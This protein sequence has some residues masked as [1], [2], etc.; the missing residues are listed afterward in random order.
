VADHIPVRRPYPGLRPFETHEAEIFFGREAHVDRLLEILQQQR[1]LAVIGPSGC[2]KSSLV[3]AGLLPAVLAGWLGTGSD[4]RIAK[5]RPGDRPLHELGRTLSAREVFDSEEETIEAELARGKRGL[6]DSFEI[7]ARR[8]NDAKR[9]NLLILVDQFEELFTYEQSRDESTE[10]VNLLLAAAK[11]D[12]RIHIVMTMRTDFLGDCVQ[13]LQLPDAINRGMFLTPRLHR[14]EMRTAITAPALL[15]GGKVD[16]QLAGQLVNGVGSESDELPILQH[17]LARMWENAKEQRKSM[18][19]LPDDLNDIGGLEHALSAHA[20]A[21]YTKLSLAQQSLAKRLFQSIT[22]RKS[23]EEGSRDVRQPRPL[24]EIAAAIPNCDWTMLVPIAEA[25]AAD[26]VNFL[27]HGSKL[28][29]KSVIDLSHE[30]LIRKWDR[31]QSWVAEEAERAAGY[32]RWR[33]R[34]ESKMMLPTV[35]LLQAIRWRDGAEGRM[36]PDANWATRYGSV[37]E[38][39]RTVAHIAASRRRRGA[40]WAAVVAVLFAVAYIGLQ[41][42]HLAAQIK[43]RDAQIKVQEA[44]HALETERTKLIADARI[45]EEQ[46]RAESDRLVAV[47]EAELQAQQKAA[48][49]ALAQTTSLEAKSRQLMSESQVNAA[50]DPERAQLLAIKAYRTHPFSESE[51]ML[52]EVRMRYASLQRTLRSSKKATYT[53]VSPDG[54]SVLTVDEDRATHLWDVAAGRQSELPSGVTE[55]AYSTNGARILLLGNGK[56]RVW[57]VAGGRVIDELSGSLGVIS[58]DGRSLATTT[59]GKAAVRQVGST[60]VVTTFGDPNET[61]TAIAFSA[62]GKLIATTSSNTLRLWSAS[63]GKPMLPPLKR[64]PKVEL[65]YE[66]RI[67]FSDDGKHLITFSDKE[68]AQ[69]WDTSTGASVAL[70]AG[71]LNDALFNADGSTVVTA[72]KDGTAASWDAS[73]GTA[74]GKIAEYGRDVAVV[75]IV[76]PRD[77]E[78]VL[79]T[80][81]DGKAQLFELPDGELLATFDA[82]DGPVNSAAFSTDGHTLVTAHDHGVRVWN[83][84]I[85]RPRRSFSGQRSKDH[86]DLPTIAAFTPDGKS[87]VAVGEETQV[88][89]LAT[90]KARPSRKNESLPVLS[91]DASTILMAGADEKTLDVLD[92]VSGRRRCVLN[93]PAVRGRGAEELDLKE[94]LAGAMIIGFLRVPALRLMLA[95]G[96]ELALSD[97]GRRVMLSDGA[98]TYVWE[99]THGKLIAKFEAKFLAP[100]FSP[101]GRLI[102]AFSEDGQISLWSVDSQRKVRSHYGEKESMASVF[103][104]DAQLFATS[105]EDAVQLWDLRND[106]LIRT[107]PHEGVMQIVFSPKGESVV[108]MDGE[109]RTL[110]WNVHTGP[111][112]TLTAPA[113]GRRATKRDEKDKTTLFAAFN[114]S[115][116][117][118]AASSEDGTIRLWDTRTGRQLAVLEGNSGSGVI[119]FDPHDKLILSTAIEDG[120]TRIWDI[121]GVTDSVDQ[122]IAAIEHRIGLKADQLAP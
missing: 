105:D 43:L 23:K 50:D 55:A 39:E 96:N 8:A 52:R 113:R 82:N 62:D 68:H 18:T 78:T 40:F 21:V 27:T 114:H 116:T 54:N 107:L 111:S 63:D 4:W 86:E 9:L 35:E 79:I 98:D 106:R 49:I 11:E 119:S 77:H 87:I 25:F 95:V 15:F 37:K 101:D 36:R 12:S 29:E 57:E 110:L 32:R 118:V 56:V 24:H 108:T 19:L 41:E 64:D 66:P 88:W 59:G 91:T 44:Q 61:I 72:G 20:D 74:I 81:A 53:S 117:V 67:V 7:A 103:S 42:A 75:K 83:R 17:A 31:L 13:F 58:R 73:T 45:A 102:A 10:F 92:A 112:I 84:H 71:Y 28:D 47:K 115:G 121:D 122:T 104:P 48:E 3:R 38:F 14:D 60:N 34:A 5:M 22:E 99:T 46:R 94:L 93:L 120:A 33:D 100:F 16:D 51:S 76:Y 85:G 70:L 2:G 90:W 1:F 65:G 109:E 26:G 80:T 69:I 6:I 30:A 89:D 97:D